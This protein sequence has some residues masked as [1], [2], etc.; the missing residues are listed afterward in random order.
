MEEDM[1]FYEKLLKTYF[2]LKTGIYKRKSNKQILEEYNKDLQ[3]YK[4]INN[5]NGYRVNHTCTSDCQIGK[6]YKSFNNN[7]KSITIN[8]MTLGTTYKK[9]YIKLEIYTELIIMTSIM[10]LGKDNN[11][12]LALIA[13][14]NFENFFRT[15][16]YKKLS[17]IFKKGK[18]I[19]VLEP[20]YK[21]FGS[22]DDGI[23]IED[24]N[25]IIIFDNKEWI[26]KFLKNES[27]E[28]NFE[29]LNDKKNDNID[30]LYKTANQLLEKRSFNNAL[31]HFIKLKSLKPDDIEID[32]KLAKCYFGLPYYTK[33]INK[34]DEIINKNQDNVDA[35][36]LK[37]KSLIYLKK[38]LEAK[39]F[40]NSKKQIIE[41]S[42]KQDFI[43]IQ[44]EITNKIKNMNGYFN[45]ADLYKQSKNSLNLNIGE[46]INKK[47]KINFDNNKGIGIYANEKIKK[48]EL[49]VVSKALAITVLNKN[50]NEKIIEYD[51]PNQEEYEKTGQLLIY[52]Y[53]KEIEEILS[54][55][56]SNYPEDFI[57]FLHLY[58]GKNIN[59]N[60]EK[61]KKESNINLKKIQDV[62]KFNSFSL[63]FFENP[64]LN[65]LWYFPSFF[66]HSCIANCYFFGFG[67]VF[68]IIS[69][70]DIES[71]NE[72]FLNYCTNQMDFKSRQKFLK[73]NYN[74]YCNCQLCQ[75]E[76]NQIEKYKEKTILDDYLKQLDIN[77]NSPLKNNCKK[78]LNQKDIEK[79]E[80]FIENN[81]KIFC[82]YEKNLFYL[83][84]A[85]CM[86]SYDLD[87]SYQYLEKALR[88]SENRNYFFEKINLLMMNLIAKELKNEN[89]IK[90]AKNKL[91]SFW[92]QYFSGQKQFIEI[93][94]NEYLI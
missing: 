59:F 20:F 8:E 73:E 92:E 48:G 39:E 46:Y 54:F 56:L 11:N 31:A 29:N 19:L 70:S 13:I 22:G 1:E 71:D 85:F 41:K 64:I 50:E 77:F 78:S 26:D 75:Y 83:K 44:Q 5:L 51:N 33:T 60:L 32:L 36:L 53:K 35:I 27:K 89:K 69:I 52:R 10:F 90:F 57:E 62:I 91:N 12:D 24:P 42:K 43:E 74:F 40:L 3:K 86:Y 4:S 9:K 2:E 87:I 49:L 55:K 45:F 37:I 23:R 72:L 84:S 88:Y 30:F 65:G 76:K 15:K 93:L 81:K 66:N 63:S 17:N 79:M 18:Y 25:E 21:M 14:Y 16:N 80:L 28:N 6:I 58:D 67:D 82:C 47:L 61:R 7:M 38:I 68:I 34:C 94:N